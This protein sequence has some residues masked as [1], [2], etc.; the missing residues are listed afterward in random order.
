MSTARAPHRSDARISSHLGGSFAAAAATISLSSVAPSAAMCRKGEWSSHPRGSR[1]RS[2]S[3]RVVAMA[4]VRRSRAAPM[5]DG[6]DFSPAA[7]AP[8]RTLRRKTSGL[9]TRM[10]AEP[11]AEP[12]EAAEGVMNMEGGFEP[13]YGVDDDYLTF[14]ELLPLPKPAHLVYI[15]PTVAVVAGKATRQSVGIQMT[16]LNNQLER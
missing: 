15:K 8:K 1:S 6:I 5:T 12:I 3:M 2:H 14:T 10:A 4:T 13:D 9:R 7:A 11:A 16:A